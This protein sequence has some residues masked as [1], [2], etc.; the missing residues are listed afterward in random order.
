MSLNKSKV[1][2]SRKSNVNVR[3]T[4]ENSSGLIIFYRIPVDNNENII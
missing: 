1:I 3:L 2:V 4:V